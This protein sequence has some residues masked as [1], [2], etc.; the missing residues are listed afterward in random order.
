MALRQ[1]DC[2]M[3][4]EERLPEDLLEDAPWIDRW[5]GT[6][7]NGE[8]V[9]HLLVDVEK[10]E[11]LLDRL[12]KAMGSSDRHR[13]V[14]LSVEATLPRQEEDEEDDSPEGGA[15]TRGEEP[16]EEDAEDEETVGRISREELYQD[17][18]DTAETSPVYALLVVL[19]A[20]VAAGG[21]ISGSTAVVIGAMVIAPLLGPSMALALASTLADGQLARKAG[22]AH[23]AGLGLGVGVAVLL[24]WMLQIDPANPAVRARSVLTLGDVALALAAGVAGA[25]SFTRGISNALIGVMVAVALLPPLVAGGMLLGVGETGAAWGGLLLA[26]TNFIAIN[27][28]GVLTFALQ[29]IRPHSWWEA[30]RARRSTRWAL[31]VWTFLLLLLVG[32]LFLFGELG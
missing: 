16:G 23:V 27:L 11:S 6:L 31:A 20:V 30:E 19:S 12:E 24:G 15:A 29:G 26:A 10:S 1:I 25:L 3:P 28:A 21:L 2:Y 9:E 4:G 17:L 5:V 8:R 13:I 7:E 14:L 18:V 32:A 22:I